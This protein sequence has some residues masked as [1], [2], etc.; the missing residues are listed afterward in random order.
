MKRKVFVCLLALAIMAGASSCICAKTLKPRDAGAPSEMSSITDSPP[1]SPSPTADEGYAALDAA[2]VPPGDGFYLVVRGTPVEFEGAFG[3]DLSSVGS[4]WYQAAVDIHSIRSPEDLPST[5]NPLPVALLQ[6]PSEEPLTWSDL[7]LIGLQVGLGFRVSERN[8]SCVVSAVPDD[9]SGWRAG[10]APGDIILAVDGQDCSGGCSRVAEKTRGKAGEE[11][12]LTVLRGTSS[13]DLT[14]VRSTIVEVV[15]IPYT[16]TPKGEFV[17]IVP[18][19]ALP[20]GIYGYAY[21]DA[22]SPYDVVYPFEV[23]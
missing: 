3:S 15:E 4:F 18:R 13:V 22:Y 12:R 1:Y 11:V 2:A 5:P 19:Q 8:D 6:L 7:R 23:E 17:Q 16:F 14:A 21:G 9:S 20:P 10:L